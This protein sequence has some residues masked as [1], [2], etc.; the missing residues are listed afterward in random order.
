MDEPHTVDVS[1]ADSTASVH[2]LTISRGLGGTVWPDVGRHTYVA[3][4]EF[5]VRATPEAGKQVASWGGACSTTPKAE[6]T[7]NVRMDMSKSV[8]VVFEDIPATVSISRNSE[9]VREGQNAVFTL[10][11]TRATTSLL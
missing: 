11:R 6:N 3:N 5:A 8:S 1:F 2:T 10:T 9:S 4:T 7:C